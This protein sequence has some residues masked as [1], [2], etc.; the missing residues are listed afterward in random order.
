MFCESDLDIIAMAKSLIEGHIASHGTD[1]DA[2]ILASDS[3]HTLDEYDPRIGGY[4][5]ARNLLRDALINDFHLRVPIYATGMNGCFNFSAGLAIAKGLLESGFHNKIL[6]VITDRA[7]RDRSRIL[8]GN[9]GV[10]GDA[11]T[12]CIISKAGGWLVRSIDLIDVPLAL[13]PGLGFLNAGKIWRDRRAHEYGGRNISFV[14]DN[15][16]WSS[17]QILAEGMRVSPDLIRFPR[18]AATGHAFACDC[19]IGLEALA[20]DHDPRLELFGMINVGAGRIGWTV[21]EPALL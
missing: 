9:I 15:L 6:Y 3:Y 11:A 10:L 1:F 13:T 19:L 16:V 2:L 18:K 14:G 20:F 5:C 4:I 7:A 21:I 12:S 17:Y 8:E